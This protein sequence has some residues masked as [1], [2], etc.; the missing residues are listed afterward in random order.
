MF[1]RLFKSREPSFKGTGLNAMDAVQKVVLA[2]VCS[3]GQA[4]ENNELI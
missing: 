4:V 1:P 2:K 3:Y